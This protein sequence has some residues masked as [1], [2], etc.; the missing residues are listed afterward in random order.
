MGFCGGAVTVVSGPAPGV[1]VA[2]PSACIR[3]ALALVTGWSPSL[4][5]DLLDSPTS[6]P[7]HGA[8]RSGQSSSS[9]SSGTSINWPS[10]GLSANIAT[11]M[12]I[13]P[14]FLPCAVSFILGILQ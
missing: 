7:L 2:P 4:P 8:S 5:A 3:G 10:S 9:T 12:P 14:D 13:C 11:C 1:T 6:V